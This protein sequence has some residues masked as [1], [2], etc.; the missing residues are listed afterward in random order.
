PMPSACFVH[1]THDE[2]HVLERRRRPRLHVRSGGW[3]EDTDGRK[4]AERRNVLDRLNCA[5]DGFNASDDLARHRAT[6]HA[7]GT[8]FERVQEKSLSKH[9]RF[10]RTDALEPVRIEEL[11]TEGQVVDAEV[12]EAVVA[13]EIFLRCELHADEHSDLFLDRFHVR[14]GEG[15]SA[16]PLEAAVE[17][18][19][20]GGRLVARRRARFNDVGQCLIQG[21]R[22]ADILTR[23]AEAAVEGRRI[24]PERADWVHVDA[25]ICTLED[26]DTIHRY[27]PGRDL[28]VPARCSW[29][30]DRV[31]HTG[32]LVEDRITIAG[33]A[34]Q[35]V[36]GACSK[37]LVDWDVDPNFVFQPRAGRQRDL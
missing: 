33:A 19:E 3:A 6:R 10:A 13:A 7:R 32:T 28:R 22:A 5:I 17:M 37:R 9:A 12:D 21:L 15:D 2:R 27:I 36:R 16:G 20:R 29:Q 24:V 23:R 11:E 31:T 18:D 1:V 34:V 26:P 4:R 8:V 30:M 35:A 25:E 14:L